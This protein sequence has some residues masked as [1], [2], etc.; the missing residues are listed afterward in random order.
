MRITTNRKWP[1]AILASALSLCFL[2]AGAQMTVAKTG[3]LAA[4]QPTLRL[5]SETPVQGA[6]MAATVTAQELQRIASDAY[7]YAYPMVLMEV[8]RRASTNVASPIEG[9]APMNQFS[10][11]TALPDANA[12][13]VSWPSTDVLYSNL[14][15]DVSSQPLIV[16]VPDNGTRYQSITLLDMWTD[17]FASRGTRVNGN[18]PQAFAIVGPYWQGTLPPGIDIVRSPTSM[19]WLIGRVETTGPSDLAAANQYQASLSATPHTA[20][21]AGTWPAVAK[22]ENWAVQGTP[23]DIVAGMDAAT[24]FGVFADAI[25]NNPPHANDHAMLDQLRRIGVGPNNQ[26]FQFARLDPV[27][28]QALVEAAPNAATRVRNAVKTLGVSQNNWMTVLSGIGSYGTDYLRRAAVAYAGLGANPPVDVIYPVAFTDARGEALDGKRDYVLHFNRA[29]LPPVDGFW[30]INLYGPNFTYVNN[31]ARRYALRSTDAL[32]YNSDGSLDIYIS[33]K[34][35]RGERQSNWLPAP[36]EGAF[37][38]NM[39]LYS[40]KDIALDGSW[41]PPPIRRD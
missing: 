29:Q 31:E 8:T 16:R 15:Y 12:Q 4:P 40:P 33:R 22:Q 30:S 18:G 35:P 34:P 24:F 32:K 27:V 17:T 23:T 19:G 41:A 38:L 5:M 21:G 2:P 9:K 10:H 6:V 20:P 28:Q 39:R 1:A 37:V 25:R 11:R 36:A 14:W 26:P 7:I 3:T 13:Q